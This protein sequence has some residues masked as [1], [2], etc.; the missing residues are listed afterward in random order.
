MPPDLGGVQILGAFNRCSQRTDPTEFLSG[1][2][3]EPDGRPPPGTD[4]LS[5]PE[6]SGIG[7][8]LVHDIFVLKVLFRP[9][10]VVRAAFSSWYPS[11]CP[12]EKIQESTF[13]RS[14]SVV[15]SG[16]SGCGQDTPKCR[17]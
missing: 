8:R 11:T 4:M 10:P 16:F 1:S 3:G 12:W 6:Y 15:S 7:D 9:V 2:V 14:G 5:T 17:I 13:C